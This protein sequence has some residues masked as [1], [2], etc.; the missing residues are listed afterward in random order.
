MNIKHY[1]ILSLAFCITTITLAQEMSFEDYNPKSTLVVPGDSIFK[2]K[3]PFIDVHGHQYRMPTQDLTSVVADMDKLNMGIMVNLS[4]RTGDQLVQSVKNIADNFPGRFVVFANIN[5]QDAGSEGWTEK[6]VAQLEQDV[7]NGA[8]GLKVYK[9]LGLSNK[10]AQGNRLAI[11]DERLDPI[12]AKCGELGIPVLIHSADPASFWDEF[13][14]DNERWLELKTHPRRKRDDTNP[15]PFQ[16]IMNEQYSII[17][18]HP[19]TTFISAHMSWL[20]N[21]LGRLGELFD[22]MPNMNVGIGAIIA[23]LGRQPRFAKAF[24]TKYQDRVLFGKDS[25]KPEEFPTYFRVLESA[26]EYFPYHK[27]YHAYWAMYG[28]DLDDEVLKKVYYKNALRIVPGL[29]KSLFPK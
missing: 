10:D 11:N 23:E 5:F 12:W 16:Q 7:K 26:D 22:E 17:K 14:G 3:F 25:W 1:F 9:S 8:R 29:D 13:D 6:M 18:K 24:I 20:A 2:A 19:N 21:D 28:L 15:A 27:K 4:G